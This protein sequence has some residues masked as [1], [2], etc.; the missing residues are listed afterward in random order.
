MAVSATLGLAFMEP[1]SLGILSKPYGP[2]EFYHLERTMPDFSFNYLSLSPK[3]SANLE[4]FINHV[5]SGQVVCIA[6]MPACD[7]TSLAANIAATFALKHGRSTCYLS[8][9]NRSEAIIKMLVNTVS[10]LTT[11]AFG[12]EI[13]SGSEIA[14]LLTGARQLHDAP[15]YLIDDAACHI[16]SLAESV[17]YLK[18]E[19]Q[20]E[21]VFIDY[22][23][24]INSAY[25]GPDRNPQLLN[26]L[27]EIATNEKIAIVVLLQ[28]DSY[29]GSDFEAH[30]ASELARLGADK[31][32]ALVVMNI[33]HDD[34]QSP[35]Q[36]HL[37]LF[38][39][40]R[41]V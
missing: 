37:R 30:V 14:Q 3:S 6:A 26:H 20:V 16:D 27:Q 2:L 1:D 22:L 15:F 21:I 31:H 4:D 10:G 41:T 24:L 40:N 38:G 8:L 34:S 33:S 29:H 25:E 5:N 32:L 18:K 28:L 7:N 17:R 39:S 13:L 19:H 12:E 36:Q 23:G 35:L 9:D 11:D